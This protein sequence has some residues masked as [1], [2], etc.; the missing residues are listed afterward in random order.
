MLRYWMLRYW[1]LRYWMLRLLHAA[2][3]QE[4]MEESKAVESL[5]FLETALPCLE[6]FLET[7]QTFHTN[8]LWTVAVSQR[9]ADK[10]VWKEYACYYHCS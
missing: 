8:S 10:V 3:Q 6:M 4:T 9:R 1:M 7:T 5:P 2:R